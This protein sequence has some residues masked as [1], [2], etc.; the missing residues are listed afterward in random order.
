LVSVEAAVN[1]F[2]PAMKCSSPVPVPLIPLKMLVPKLEP[3][4]ISA[5]APVS[6]VPVWLLVP[7]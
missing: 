3:K 4:R 6:N 2:V 7:A 1:V 5:P